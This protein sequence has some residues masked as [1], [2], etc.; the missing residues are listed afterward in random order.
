MVSSFNRI[1]VLGH[2]N[3][4]LSDGW[5]SYFKKQILADYLNFSIGGSPSPALLMRVLLNE[6]KI[7]DV[8]LVIIEPCVID[9][10][11]EWQD[12]QA[13]YK[14]AVILI[15][16]FQ[17]KG[18]SVIL[19]AIPR[20]SEAVDKKTRGMMSW[21]KAAT[22]YKIAYLDCTNSIKNFSIT[23]GVNLELCWR[24]NMGHLTA[25]VQSFVADDLIY[26]LANINLNMSAKLSKDLFKVITAKMLF[27]YSEG[28]ELIERKSSFDSS[29]CISLKVNSTILVDVLPQFLVYGLLLNYGEMSS[30]DRSII[31]F[32]TGDESTEV[33]VQNKF[34]A[35]LPS[36]KFLAM[37]RSITPLKD[38]SKITIPLENNSAY[39]ES[40]ANRIEII[41]ILIGKPL[42]EVL[43]N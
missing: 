14:H 7:K 22:D 24:D 40:G 5:L 23:N 2:S 29:L 13:I 10:G 43:I 17:S 30:N 26:K 32:L 1:L 8:D 31:T 33:P 36:R 42:S 19:L 39:L 3:S 21:I 28:S 35:K 38:V 41:G 25:D 11:E 18:I 9:H 27:E 6:G 15:D 20:N 37:Y 34:S 4:I 16:Y 12:P